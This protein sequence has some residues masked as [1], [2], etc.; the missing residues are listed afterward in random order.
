MSLFLN[1][2]D[3]AVSFINLWCVRSCP[4]SVWSHQCDLNIQTCVH[5]AADLKES[6]CHV[7]EWNRFSLFNHTVSL[8]LCYKHSNIHRS[9]GIKVYSSD[10]NSDL[11]VSDQN[12]VAKSPFESNLTLQIKIYRLRC[13]ACIG[14]E[15]GLLKCL[16]SLIQEI[17]SQMLIHPVMKQV[18]LDSVIESFIH[19]LHVI[20][21]S[22]LIFF[23]RI[24]RD[25]ESPLKN[26]QTQF[27]QNHAA[28]KRAQ[29]LC[30]LLIFVYG[31]QLQLNVLQ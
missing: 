27:I 22:C 29:F 18:N 13:Y 31:L 17:C 23:F 30:G 8:F 14:G 9:T 2:N 28:L 24:L 5:A 12:R 6:S 11:Y 21:F 20:L 16:E 26:K 19:K 3:S 25:P 7:Y 10:I 15:K 1:Y 4:C